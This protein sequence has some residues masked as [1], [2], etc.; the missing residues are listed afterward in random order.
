MQGWRIGGK[1]PAYGWFTVHV[2]G[3][4]V[5]SKSPDLAE[6]KARILAADDD[7]QRGS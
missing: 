2:D 3:Q 4:I 5:S 1:L 6:R 7:T